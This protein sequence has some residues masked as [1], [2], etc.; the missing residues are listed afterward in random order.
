LGIFYKRK[1]EAFQTALKTF[2]DVRKLHE[3]EVLGPL[4][5]MEDFVATL[6]ETTEMQKMEVNGLKDR[7]FNRFNQLEYAK[8]L[9]ERNEDPR[10]KQL[11]LAQPMDPGRTKKFQE[12]EKLYL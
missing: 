4:N 1:D 6:Q 10:Y 7:I 5:T 3:E 9:A 8:A 11:Q 2:S 12:I